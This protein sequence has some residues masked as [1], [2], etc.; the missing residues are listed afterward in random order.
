MRQRKAEIEEH[1]KG[2]KKEKKRKRIRKLRIF[3]SF[4]FFYYYYF[5]LFIKHSHICYRG[6]RFF[7]RCAN[8]DRVLILFFYFSQSKLV[9]SHNEMP[10]QFYSSSNFLFLSTM[11]FFF[12]FTFESVSIGWKRCFPLSLI[13]R[14]DDLKFLTPS[15]ARRESYTQHGV[16]FAFPVNCRSNLQSCRLFLIEF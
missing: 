9:A 2:R 11:F 8:F 12:F 5:Y 3:F 14:R 16:N 4:L 13:L 1:K 6:H 7:T 15:Q 10:N